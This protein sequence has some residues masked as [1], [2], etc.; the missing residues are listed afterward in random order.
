[1]QI[2]YFNGSPRINGTTATL[3]N[4]ALEGA[5]SQGAKTEFIQ[6]NRIKMKGCQACYSCKKIGSKNFGKCALVDGM[7]PLY[8]KIEQADA[9]FLG[10]PIYFGTVTAAAKMFI[11]R[12]FP[13]LSYRKPRSSIFPKK[14][15]A[16]LIFTMGVEEQIMEK[17]Y[18]PNIQ[19]YK[20]VLTDLLGSAET[21]ISTDTLHVEDYSKIAADWMET[22]A[23]RK[24]EHRR[25]VFPLDCEKAFNMGARF[26]APEKI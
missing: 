17:E 9:I 11:E 23:E 25:T 21:I 18:W 6:L 8:E 24:L 5:A 19:F 14:I 4:K 16:G 1:M 13:Y 12:L 7:T 22:Q 20:N 3:L 10:S 26:A 2:I 15:H